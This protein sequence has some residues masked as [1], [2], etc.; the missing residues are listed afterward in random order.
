[1][2]STPDKEKDDV[3]VRPFA[4]FLID[5]HSGVTAA[6]LSDKLH[7]LVSAVHDTGKKG[8]LTLSIVVEPFKGDTET[9]YVTA[10]IK[11]KIP[12]E[13]RRGAVFFPDADG[14]LRR[15]DPRRPHLPLKELGGKE[16]AVDIKSE[17]KEA[18]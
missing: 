14:N 13:P 16:G 11:A 4:D 9:M 12:E 17:L 8:T 5:H 3:Q 15:E 10:D 7:E 2:A 1:M 6:E 18:K